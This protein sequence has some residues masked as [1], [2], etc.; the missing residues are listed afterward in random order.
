MRAK[1]I[2]LGVLGA[3]VTTAAIF[4]IRRP[5]V[6]PSPAMSPAVDGIRVTAMPNFVSEPESDEEP[7]REPER[8][9]DPGQTMQMARTIRDPAA[10]KPFLEAM[11][12]RAHERG[13]VSNVEIEAGIVAIE[14]AIGPLRDG[15][16]GTQV[17]AFR[18]K[19]ITLSRALADARNPISH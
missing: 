3:V 17:E 10:L 7:L 12:K 5:P 14:H 6:A 11:E 15:S 13:V 1:I 8:L 4:V 16:L 18:S 19:M 9:E 2:Q